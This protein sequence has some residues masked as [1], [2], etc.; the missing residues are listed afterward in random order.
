MNRY[1]FISAACV[2][3][4]VS[5]SEKKEMDI[6]PEQYRTVIYVKENSTEYV[7]V[8]ATADDPTYDFTVCKAGSDITARVEASVTPLTQSEVD[9]EFNSLGAGVEYRV[10]PADAYT[11]N[12]PSAL[13]FSED[14]TYKVVSY[15]LISGKLAQLSAANPGVRYIIGFRLSSERTSVNGKCSRYICEISDVIV[16]AL[17]FERAGLN[18]VSAAID[19]TW[20]EDRMEISIPVEVKSLDNRWDID[21]K[22]MVDRDWLETY[23]A[24]NMTDY[25]LPADGYETSSSVSLRSTEQKAYVKV[26]I[27]GVSRL[28]K[29]VML[30]LR[31]TDASQFKVSDADGVCALLIDPAI[32]YPVEIDRSAWKWQECC[33]EPW[34]NGGNCSAYYMIDNDINSYWHYSWEASSPCKGRENHCF[35]FD[36][37]ATQT[38]SGFGYVGR[39]NMWSGNALNALSFFVSDDDS[40]WGQSV[41]DHTGWRKIVDAASV[42]SG[43]AEQSIPARLSR[44]RYLKVMVAGSNGT[45]GNNGVMKGCIAEIKVYGKSL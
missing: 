28:L 26:T 25:T 40:V 33:H 17:G 2:A 13:N 27:S 31:L 10:L 23:N 8:D 18:R 14:E 44:G 43:N 7:T 37:G 20:P 16:P 45:E 39:Q 29:P 12:T 30:P 19:E 38:I 34:E 35:V 15:T 4:A 41:H 42:D 24:V 9:E 32:K 36:M 22:V 5:C 3:L 11:V 6:F 1:T 21:A